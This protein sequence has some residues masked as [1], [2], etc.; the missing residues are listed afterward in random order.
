MQ[1]ML[2][3]SLQSFGIL[4][5]EYPPARQNEDVAILLTLLA[6]ALHLSMYTGRGE[7]RL[8]E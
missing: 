7:E 8:K 5:R 2:W 1:D 4:G 3:S 6:L